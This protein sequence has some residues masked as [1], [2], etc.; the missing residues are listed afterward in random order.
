MEK[1]SKEELFKQI[2]TIAQNK[3]VYVGRPEDVKVDILISSDGVSDLDMDSLDT[4]ELIM[5]LEDHFMIEIDD[6]AASACTNVQQFVDLVH[7]RIK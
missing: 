1:P 3:G 7:E 4:V 2:I 6:G 5:A